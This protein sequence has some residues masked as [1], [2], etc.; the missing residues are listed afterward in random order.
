MPSA[1]ST[2]TASSAMTSRSYGPSGLSR[3]AGAAVVDEDQ[4][5][6]ARRARS[7]GPTQP[8]VS[9]PRPWIRSSGSPSA[10]P[11]DL[12]VDPRP[13][14]G[15]RERHVNREHNGTQRNR[16]RHLRPSSQPSGVDV[17]DRARRRPWP[18]PR[19]HQVPGAQQRRR[20]RRV[21][22][23]AAEAAQ[24][25]ADGRDVGDAEHP[26]AAGRL[27]GSTAAA[28]TTGSVGARRRRGATSSAG[29]SAMRSSP[30]TEID[31]RTPASGRHERQQVDVETPRV[32]LEGPLDPPRHDRGEVAHG[33]HAA[34]RCG[35]CDGPERGH[36]RPLV[37]VPDDLGGRARGA[38]SP[39]RASKAAAVGRPAAPQ[40]LDDVAR[41]AARPR[42]RRCGR[43]PATPGRR[44]ARHAA[45]EPRRLR[46][47]HRAGGDDVVGA[48]GAGSS[49]CTTARAASS[50]CSSEN[51]GSA[52]ALHADDRAAAGS[53]PSGLGTWGPTTGASRSAATRHGAVRTSDSTRTQR[54]AEAR[55][56][57]RRAPT[58]RAPTARRAVGRTPRCPTAPR[59]TARSATASSTATVPAD[60][61]LRGIARRRAG[62]R[63]E[64][65]EV[66]ER[67][68]CEVAHGAHRAHTVAR[69]DADERRLRRGAAGAAG[70]CRCRRRRRPR[71]RCSSS[72]ATRVPS[73]PPMPVTR[74]RE[75]HPA[76]VAGSGRG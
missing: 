29:P 5:V 42:A 25:R 45:T 13:V 66:H 60:G 46:C 16:T 70:R 10:R 47:G 67:R 31:H 22:D 8:F 39:T 3:P 38:G 75:R 59:S 52:T 51:A 36:R 53:D 15:H 32:D 34:F 41:A 33:A 74:T 6:P 40:Q 2:A 44:P 72:V 49:A 12:V 57:G 21:V 23:D 24:E 37:Q 19:E 61:L 17:H 65:A 43:R 63:L 28:S 73:S 27:T 56:S 71:A 4:A 55:S 30:S 76:R 50:A 54:V 58:R 9:A 48:V 64:H 7:A 35:S 69:V 62:V 26:A 68:R 14:G 18:V 20:L 1:S 11:G